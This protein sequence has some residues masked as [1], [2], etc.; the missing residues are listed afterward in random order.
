MSTLLNRE[1]LDAHQLSLTDVQL[2]DLLANS[3]GGTVQLAELAD[4]V[5]LLPSRLTRHIRRLQERGLLARMM[6]PQDRRRVVAVITEAGK[7]LVEQALITYANTVR[8]HF[9]GPLTHPQIAAVA[10]TCRHIGDGLKT[11]RP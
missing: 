9:L 2:L 8:T 10:T 5:A 3:P 7:T 1:L 11:A 6:D 4:A